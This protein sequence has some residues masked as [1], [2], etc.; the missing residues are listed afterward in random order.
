M[1]WSSDLVRKPRRKPHTGQRNFAQRCTAI[2]VKFSITRI[3]EDD[4]GAA[5]GP[6]LRTQRVRR[7]AAAF[8]DPDDEPRGGPPSCVEDQRQ[9]VAQSSI[10]LAPQLFVGGEHASFG[11]RA[12]ELDAPRSPRWIGREIATTLRPVYHQLAEP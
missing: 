11:P 2:E 8:R 6:Q 5:G 1:R 9:P 10:V 3:A 7:R 4:A 12:S